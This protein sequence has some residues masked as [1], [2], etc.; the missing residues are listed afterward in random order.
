MFGI[1]STVRTM[2]GPA[3]SGGVVCCPIVAAA[4]ARGASSDVNDVAEIVIERIRVLEAAD[5]AGLVF[6]LHAQDVV[7]RAHQ[8]EN[9]E[10]SN[11]ETFRPS[12]TMLES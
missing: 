12:M 8:R 9:T 6:P 1:S 7:G 3:L 4:Q 2:S 10:R 11:F 5:D